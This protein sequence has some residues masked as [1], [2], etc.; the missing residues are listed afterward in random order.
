MRE[1][2]T[3]FPWGWL[4]P[5]MLIALA[6]Q[7]G[8]QTALFDE[9][10][11]TSACDQQRCVA[12][13]EAVIQ[14]LRDRTLPEP[15]FNGQI[16]F[17]AAILLQRAETADPALLPKLGA[18]LGMLGESSSDARQGAAIAEVAEAVAG[19]QAGNLAASTP[20]AASPSRPPGL[21]RPPPPFRSGPGPGLNRSPWSDFWQR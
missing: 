7:V 19:G 4:A 15:D 18:A 17:L 10:A 9:S 12:E 1:F 13:V 21:N 8:A 3:R 5:A 2:P 11:L 20:Y 6:G 14:S 16:G